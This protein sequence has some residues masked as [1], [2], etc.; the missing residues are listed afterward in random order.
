MHSSELEKS[1]LTGFSSVTS[2]PKYSA[3]LIIWFTILS[4]SFKNQIQIQFISMAFT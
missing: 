3:T 4:N 2:H 1:Q